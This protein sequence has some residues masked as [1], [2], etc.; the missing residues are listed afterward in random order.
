MWKQSQHRTVKLIHQGQ[1]A[2]SWG[3]G[4][5]CIGVVMCW[6]LKCVYIQQQLQPGVA[7]GFKA[8]RSKQG[9]SVATR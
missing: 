9:S 1:R 5:C 6:E 7:K 2:C 3:R 4:Q 8:S